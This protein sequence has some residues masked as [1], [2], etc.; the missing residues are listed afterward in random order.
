MNKH[1]DAAVKKTGIT[2]PRHKVDGKLRT[3]QRKGERSVYE[4]LKYEWLTSSSPANEPFGNAKN[5][6]SK[7]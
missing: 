7:S 6:T 1:K 5:A 4:A 3:E 2:S